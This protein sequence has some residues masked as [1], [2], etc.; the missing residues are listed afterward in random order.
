[1][2][3]IYAQDGQTEWKTGEKERL[4]DGS[5]NGDSVKGSARAEDADGQGV[6]TF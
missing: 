2:I 6:E 1:M 4:V 5:K 3:F